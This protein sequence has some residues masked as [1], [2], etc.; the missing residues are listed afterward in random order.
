MRRKR[1]RTVILAALVLVSALALHERSAGQDPAGDPG[2]DPAREADSVRISDLEE[3]LSPAGER[4]IE[5]ADPAPTAPSGR[6]GWRAAWKF[7]AGALLQEPAGYLDGHFAGDRLKLFQ[8]V[9]VSEA[10]RFAAEFLADKDPGEPSAAEFVSGALSGR[11][12]SGSLRV[13][14]GDFRMRSGQGLLFGGGRSF[15]KG[16]AA[17]APA[18]RDA[19]GLAGGIS[20]D[21]ARFFRGG[22]LQAVAGPVS[23]VAFA[24]HRRAT[25]LIGADGA[26][27][28]LDA[29]GYHR[30]PAELA[31]KGALRERSAGGALRI[32]VDGI[33]AVGGS[34]LSTAMDVP[35]KNARTVEPGRIVRRRWSVEG[36]ISIAGATLFAEALPGPGP[37]PWIAGALIDGGPGTKFVLL[38][39]R[40]PPA[41]Q[42]EGAAG[43]SD[44]A[45]GANEEGTYL[46]ADLLLRGSVT[47]SAYIDLHSRLAPARGAVH[48]A[49]GVD[50]LLRVMAPLSGTCSLEL[51]FRS[52][53]GEGPSAGA[54]SP[55]LAVP[56]NA[57]SGERR[58]RIEVRYTPG[59]GV[60]CAL[61]LD[62]CIAHPPSATRADRGGMVSAGIAAPLWKRL[63]IDAR[64]RFF[65]ATSFDA[66]I[67]AVEADIPGTIVSTTYWGGGIAWSAGCSW[68]WSR[69]VRL[70]MRYSLLR[71]DDLRQI[72]SGPSELPSNVR[73]KAGLQLDVVI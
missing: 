45:G 52:R 28:G 46:G 11:L 17:V 15:S 54:A 44:A 50:A 36:R 9:S 48:P 49:R 30:T 31:R 13:V 51:R 41:S 24:S 34:L 7:R 35:G 21:E 38:R 29:S 59:G 33:F 57:A 20:S 70:S 72:G 58:G 3:Q 32:S 6:R 43:F 42:E 23:A 53:L 16:A 2:A 66:G 27:R 40:Y 26:L 18:F 5:R 61:R 68:S 60:E 4:E 25:P 73:E 10:D 8:K 71:R 39:R 37:A 56:G 67:P 47:I 12:L 14:A 1:R 64:V 55:V 19:W 22:A 62:G 63:T 69:M 65:R